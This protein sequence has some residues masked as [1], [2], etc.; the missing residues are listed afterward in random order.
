MVSTYG[1]RVEREPNHISSTNFFEG[2]YRTNAD[3]GL[4]FRTEEVCGITAKRETTDAPDVSSQPS[5]PDQRFSNFLTPK[6]L[7]LASIYDCTSD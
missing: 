3:S 7:Q 5:F 6:I 4:D 1:R 2:I